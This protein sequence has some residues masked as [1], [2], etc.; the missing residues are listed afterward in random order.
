M[1]LT[2]RR[3]GSPTSTAT[4]AASFDNSN[5]GGIVDILFPMG[6]LLSIRQGTAAR[7]ATREG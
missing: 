6:V 5:N 4:S 2:T 1:K 3:S 7:Q